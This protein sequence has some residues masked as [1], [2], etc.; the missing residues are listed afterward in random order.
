[1]LILEYVFIIKVNCKDKFYRVECWFKNGY[2]FEW[3]INLKKN[4]RKKE[5][6]ELEVNEEIKRKKMK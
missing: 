6:F 1:M 3:E 5:N 4:E 2:F